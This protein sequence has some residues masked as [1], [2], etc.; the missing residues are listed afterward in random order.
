MPIKS[1]PI[2]E[3]PEEAFQRRTH[4]SV[5]TDTIEGIKASESKKA[6]IT[7]DTPQELDKF[8]KTL[9]QWRSRHKGEGVQ[10][11]KTKDV[12]YVWIEE[13]GSGTGAGKKAKTD[14][15]AESEDA[16][17]QET[18]TPGQAKKAASTASRRSGR[19]PTE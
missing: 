2:K 15:E 13:P 1:K 5:C 16:S 10:F 6:E 11:R 19:T 9:I 3:I 17:R 18:V 12:L 8:Y 7:A 14:K 4:S